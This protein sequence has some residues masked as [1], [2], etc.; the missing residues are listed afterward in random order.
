MSTRI[1]KIN[2]KEKLKNMYTYS[3]INY[4]YFHIKLVI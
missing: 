4:I 2:E 1:S 3:A